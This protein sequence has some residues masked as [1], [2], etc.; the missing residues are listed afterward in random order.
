MKASEVCL[1]ANIFVASL[2]REPA[3]ESCLELMQHIE[4]HQSA[5]FEPALL[6][7]EVTSSFR[8]K[9][10]RGEL[11]GA[12]AERGL[13]IFFNLPLLLQWQDF[14]M[15][16]SIRFAEQL[17]FKNTYDSAY[18]AVAETRGIPLVTLDAEL[19]AKG[20]RL[21]RDIYTPEQFLRVPRA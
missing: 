14:L 19:Q 3:Q 12:E 1:D 16:K 9:Q 6:V 18:L 21:Y 20:K 4:Q 5:L 15:Q 11:N 13:E 2:T 17:K 7:F 8:K 10:L